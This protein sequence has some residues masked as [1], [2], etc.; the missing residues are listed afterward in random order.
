MLGRSQDSVRKAL[1]SSTV[2]LPPPRQIHL[3]LVFL[4]DVAVDSLPDLRTALTSIARGHPRISLSVAGLGCFPTPQRPRILWAGL[5]G[6][7]GSLQRL[8]STLAAGI[9]RF[10]SHLED[11]PFH[12][13]L[14]LGR[15]ARFPLAAEATK[16]LAACLARSY[17]PQNWAV[18]ALHLVRSRL[19]QSGA[20]YESLGAYPLLG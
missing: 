2:R 14:T 8:Q 10:G 20:H 3:T 6:E 5:A 1:G 4:G 13:H 15:F 19:T 11:K 16:A 18:D 7:T 12:P 17:P 9:A